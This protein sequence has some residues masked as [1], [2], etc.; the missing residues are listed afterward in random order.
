MLTK[1]EAATL[2]R[3]SKVILLL[4]VAM[5]GIAPI[6]LYML[7]P[8][9]PTLAVTFNGDI[10]IAQMTVSLF[11]V[12]IAISQMVMG[13]LSDK[14]GRKP[15]LL[16]GLGL[17]VIATI[18]CAFAASLPQLIVLRFLQALGGA[19]GMVISRAII[20]DLYTRERVGGMISLVIAVMMIVQML[21]PLMGGLIETNFGWRAIF[22]ALAAA[23]IATVL[24]IAFALPETRRRGPA[25][26]D[27]G[28]R[29]DMGA[30]FGSRAFVGYVLCYVFA[31]ALIFV[32]AGAGPF[33]VVN[34][35]GRTSAEYGAWFAT[36]G[37]AYL[38]GNLFSA[39][40]SP[41]IGI[42]RM[43][44]IGLVIQISGAALN[45]VF[46]FA[47]INQ[48]PV[49]LFGAHMLVTFGNAFVM[50]NTAAGAISIRP[51]A[52][53]S[54]SGIMGFSQ[55]G[56][57]AFISQGGAYLGGHFATPLPMNI[58][59]FAMSLACAAM[60][61]FVVPR[62]PAAVTTEDA[63]KAEEEESALL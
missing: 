62:R 33:I 40:Y 26:D 11:M 39:R 3:P 36:S 7:V 20:R 34:Q 50:S 35:M 63:K 54:A 48:A 32:F 12:G 51:Q 24:G 56:I 27:S 41:R 53:G 43:I 46:G 31:S 45:L 1:T 57:G 60:M 6:A 49:W 25:T 30:L 5:T 58:A 47:G 15:V 2:A 61:L 37:L 21:S 59:L 4:L 16:G 19:T 29:R 10:S 13:P 42:E 28:F 18:G 55:M 52:A 14:F 38:T 23:S 17:A 22:Y 44:W 8:A 9:L